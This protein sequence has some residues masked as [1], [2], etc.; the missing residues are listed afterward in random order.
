MIR[1]RVRVRVRVR[2]RVRVRVRVRVKVR[3]GCFGI[4]RG[5]KGLLCVAEG[6]GAAR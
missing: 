1:V 4:T 6:G 2:I 3:A 5:H